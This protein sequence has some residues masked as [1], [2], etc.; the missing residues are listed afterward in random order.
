MHLFL[1]VTCFLF[2]FF[3]LKY[4]VE[5][6][7]IKIKCGLSMIIKPHWR[8]CIECE[9]FYFDKIFPVLSF[10]YFFIVSSFT[11]V[12][13]LPYS[14]CLPNFVVL[15]LLYFPNSFAFKPPVCLLPLILLSVPNLGK[16]SHVTLGAT[17]AN[18]TS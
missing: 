8:T 5:I 10:I 18:S 2:L 11:N 9:S 4:K 17:E 13:K 6:F 3:R 15:Y 14:L 16:S 1:M 7:R 12:I